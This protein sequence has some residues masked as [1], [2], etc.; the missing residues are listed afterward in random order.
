MGD[1]AL[2]PD[3]DFMRNYARFGS[4]KHFI[5]FLWCYQP[6]HTIDL[7]IGTFDS[8]KQGRYYCGIFF[9]PGIVYLVPLNRTEESYALNMLK[10]SLQFSENSLNLCKNECFI[11][12]RPM[13]LK[14]YLSSEDVKG[15]GIVS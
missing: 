10:E 3:F 7:F 1:K 5:P 13:E 12:R 8:K 15:N 6:Q 4:R 2:Q 14:A 9:L 11:K